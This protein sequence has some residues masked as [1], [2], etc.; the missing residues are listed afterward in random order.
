MRCHCLAECSCTHSLVVNRDRSGARYVRLRRLTGQ[1]ERI[2]GFDLV[3]RG[4]PL[5]TTANR[6]FSTY[7]GTVAQ[8]LQRMQCSLH[9][10]CSMQRAPSI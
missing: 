6:Q 4:G 9:E 3:Y 5:P 7:L 8:N 1:E 10:P 2:G